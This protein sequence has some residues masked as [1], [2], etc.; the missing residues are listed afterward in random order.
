VITTTGLMVGLYAGTESVVAV[1]GGVMV[2]A[3]ADAMSDALGIHVAQEADP[4]ATAAHIWAATFAALIAKF[5]VASSFA[6]PL[7]WL[8]LSAGIVVA[9]AWGVI[10]VTVVSIQLA[11]SRGAR[12]LP[13]VTEHLAVGSL[14][15]VLSHLTGRWINDAFS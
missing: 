8:P 1:V 14:V 6:L 13:I 2:I 12:A 4:S 5:L 9:L 3:V 11:R 15:I 7:L 10:V